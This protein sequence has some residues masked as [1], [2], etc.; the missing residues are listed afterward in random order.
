MS[1][2]LFYEGFFILLFWGVYLENAMLQKFGI[3]NHQRSATFYCIETE[4][5]QAQES[6]VKKQMKL[7]KRIVA[8][9]TLLESKFFMVENRH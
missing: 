8:K 6:K 2:M 5:K 9:T 3:D 7:N 4:R 1:P